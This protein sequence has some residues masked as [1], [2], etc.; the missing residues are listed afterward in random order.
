MAI[1]QSVAHN[2]AVPPTCCIGQNVDWM[3]HVEAHAAVY[4]ELSEVDELTRSNN[5]NLNKTLWPWRSTSI[6]HS[7]WRSQSKRLTFHKPEI[8]EWCRISHEQDVDSYWFTVGPFNA[9]WEIN[10][11]FIY[12]HFWILQLLLAYVRICVNWCITVSLELQIR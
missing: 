10:A 4:R 7:C 3:S 9:F 2:W 11:F 1:G 8:G 5:F 6:T 12:V